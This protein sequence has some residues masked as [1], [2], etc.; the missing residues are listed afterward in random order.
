MGAV[1]Q[2]LQIVN[3]EK[4]SSVRLRAVRSLGNVRSD[5]AG[6]ALA[7][8][9]G[10]GDRDT[11]Q[12]VITALGNQNN[13]ESLVTIARKETDPE[14]RRQIVERLANMAKTSKAAM[15]YLMEL[16]NK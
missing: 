15:D 1:D 11:K 9:Y 3:T 14:L 10:M 8:M 16:I 4:D 6:P 5:K 2:L 12:A 13:A 7:T